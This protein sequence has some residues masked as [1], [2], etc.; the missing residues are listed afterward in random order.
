MTSNEMKETIKDLK[1]LD[2]VKTQLWYLAETKQEVK[3]IK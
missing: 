3:D 1:Q 2:K